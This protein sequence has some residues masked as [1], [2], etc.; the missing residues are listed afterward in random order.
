MRS[1]D[2]QLVKFSGLRWRSVCL[3]TP[4]PW[5]VRVWAPPVLA[6]LAASVGWVKA[7]GYSHKKFMGWAWQ[8]VLQLACYLDAS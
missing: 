5:A 6:V 2:S 7:L 8:A 1:S 4:V 3:R